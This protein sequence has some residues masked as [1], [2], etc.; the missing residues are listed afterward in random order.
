MELTKVPL[1]FTI[2]KLV[3]VST[4]SLHV[5]PAVWDTSR[6]KEVDELVER[7]GILAGVVPELSRI[8]GVCGVGPRVPLLR[9]NEVWELG[10]IT[11][12]E[13]GCIVEYLKRR[14]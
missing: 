12:E 11:Q 6:S 13:D 2:D 5:S 3:R 4:V 8:I 1:A 7:F 9:M 10:G 14:G